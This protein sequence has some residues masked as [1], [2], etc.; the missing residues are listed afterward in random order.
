M[1]KFNKFGRNKFGIGIIVL[2][3]AVTLALGGWWLMSSRSEE[4]D[5]DI[6]MPNNS[7]QVVDDEGD[8]LILA[9]TKALDMGDTITSNHY[10]RTPVDPSMV[11]IDGV[12]DPS[13]FVGMTVKTPIKEG[14][15]IVKSKLTDE[16]I[17]YKD[18]GRLTEY[19]FVEGTI[20]TIISRN[21]LVGS[22]VD[23]VLY[24]ENELDTVVL[25]KEM[26]VAEKNDNLGF[27]LT[28]EEDEVLREAG[29]E[30]SFYFR[31]YLDEDQDPAAVT[32]TPEYIDD[33]AAQRR[34]ML[35]ERQ[36]EILGESEAQNKG[37]GDSND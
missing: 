10:N 6:V 3:V 18:G 2:I 13:Y 31:I 5:E 35:E 22:L 7:E 27:H 9:A 29:A 32:Y 19:S 37:V 34:A 23:I 24:R 26:I 8:V 20:P 25:S 28:E 17:W 1:R 16:E 30:G 15:P 14:E 4:N 36:K 11:P 12:D 33:G 21:K